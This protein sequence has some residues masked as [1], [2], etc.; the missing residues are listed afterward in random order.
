[1]VKK[2]MM[3]SMSQQNKEVMARAFAGNAVSAFLKKLKIA[4]QKKTKSR[5]KAIKRKN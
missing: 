3:E 1:M 5:K 4:S 2:G